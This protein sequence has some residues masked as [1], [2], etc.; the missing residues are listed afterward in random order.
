MLPLRFLSTSKFNDGF[1]DRLE[2]LCTTY[3]LH[4]H[5][6]LCA[7]TQGENE[8]PRPS[9]SA[10]HSGTGSLDLWLVVPLLKASRPEGPL[11]SS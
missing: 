6:C 8:V 11:H 3:L 7:H 9:V 1:I 2:H 4:A 10:H 5:V